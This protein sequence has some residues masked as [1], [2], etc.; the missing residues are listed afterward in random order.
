MWKRCDSL[1]IDSQDEERHQMPPWFWEMAALEVSTLMGR[2]TPSTSLCYKTGWRVLFFFF[3]LN[4]FCS[5]RTLSLSPCEWITQLRGSVSAASYARI[6]RLLLSQAF[7][8]ICG[9][10]RNYPTTSLEMQNSWEFS[11]LEHVNGNLWEH[12]RNLNILGM[13]HVIAY[14]CVVSS[15]RLSSLGFV[16]TESS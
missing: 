8:L 16:C 11:K 4:I 9:S 7:L 10:K 13:F 2:T 6:L 15:S 1:C 12:T 5:H 3:F 14:D